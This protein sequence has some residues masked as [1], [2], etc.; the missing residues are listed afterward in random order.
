MKC[1]LSFSV[2]LAVTLSVPVPAHA[3][4][5]LEKVFAALKEQRAKKRG[6][7]ILVLYGAGEALGAANAHMKVRRRIPPNFCQPPD[8]R[9][10]ALEYADIAIKEFERNRARYDRVPFYEKD[11]VYAFIKALFDGLV[12]AYPCK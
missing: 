6:E 2:L 1:A 10:D 4:P 9:L 7:L 12:R 8:T 5:R 3:G 11:P